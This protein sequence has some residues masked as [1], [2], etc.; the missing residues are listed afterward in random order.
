M[1]FSA[2]DSNGYLGD[3]ASIGGWTA[4]AK[5]AAPQGYDV[6]ELIR[7]GHSADPR[8][9]ALQLNGMHSEDPDVE[10]VRKTLFDLAQKAEELLIVSEGEG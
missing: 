10:S 7:Q 5:W 9:V 8:A 3:V 4:F 2:Y 1:T 6:T